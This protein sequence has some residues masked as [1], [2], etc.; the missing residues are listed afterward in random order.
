MK[1]I[2]CKKK[3]TVN[4]ETKQPDGAV[5]VIALPTPSSKHGESLEEIKVNAPQMWAQIRTNPQYG[6]LC[7]DCFNPKNLNDYNDFLSK[8]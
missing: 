4:K 8:M 6:F 3:I 1:C 7:D 5:S 2:T